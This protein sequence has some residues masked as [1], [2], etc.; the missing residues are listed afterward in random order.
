MATLERA[1]ALV[2]Y[3]KTIRLDQ[4]SEFVSRD[5]GL[6][7]YGKGITLDFS[8][9]AKPTDNAFIEAFNGTL[10]QECL[11][12]HWVLS[13]ADAREKLEAWRRFDNEDRPHSAIGYNIPVS[14]AVHDG[15]SGP[16]P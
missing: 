12:A 6:W 8:L 13:L 10:R 15:A 16:P 14:L 1:C 9:P 3:P 5:L 4:G 7:A 2:G 11:S